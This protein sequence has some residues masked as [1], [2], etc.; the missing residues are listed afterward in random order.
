M[1]SS[2]D[3]KHTPSAVDTSTEVTPSLETCRMGR[4]QLI[5]TRNSHIT[6][7]TTGTRQISHSYLPDVASF[8]VKEEHVLVLNSKLFLELGKV[9]LM[10]SDM[11]NDQ[12]GPKVALS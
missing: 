11:G 7:T 12:S 1:P 9:G 10:F 5:Q 8:I 4:F 3:L 6:A 2:N